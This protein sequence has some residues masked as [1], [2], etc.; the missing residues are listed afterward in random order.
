MYS[1]ILNKTQDLDVYNASLL[2]SS[3]AQISVGTLSFLKTR[4][5]LST[6]SLVIWVVLTS[7]LLSTIALFILRLLDTS[8]LFEPIVIGLLFIGLLLGVT[9]FVYLAAKA[10]NQA[11]AEYK[12]YKKA[13]RWLKRGFPVVIAASENPPEN[14]LLL[15]KNFL[16]FDQAA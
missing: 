12:A 15:D 6:R 14:D 3:D 13:E 9:T 5:E 8:R 4:I 16:Y 7:M 11:S 2:L 1:R 10:L